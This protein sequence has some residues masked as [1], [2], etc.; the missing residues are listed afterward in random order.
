MSW[1]YRGLFDHGAVDRIDQVVKKLGVQCLGKSIAGVAGLLEG[2]G[3]GSLLGFS[4]PSAL[5]DTS[6]ELLIQ[7]ARVQPL[8]EQCEIIKAVETD[9]VPRGKQGTQESLD[10]GQPHSCQIQQSR[11]CRGGESQRQS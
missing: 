6:G 2:Q 9:G 4:T 8:E 7:N 5:H 3:D 11:C 1:P 10:R